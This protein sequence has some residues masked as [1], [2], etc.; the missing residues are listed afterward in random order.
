MSSARPSGRVARDDADGRSPDNEDPQHENADPDEVFSL[1]D[2]RVMS[3]RVP[4]NES[5]EQHKRQ[6][7]PPDGEADDDRGRFLPRSRTHQTSRRPSRF[8]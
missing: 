4:H 1:T 5:Q 8:T 3:R 7:E 6:G 2:W